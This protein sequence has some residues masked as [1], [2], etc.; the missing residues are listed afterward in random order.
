M[1]QESIVLQKLHNA[2]FE[3]ESDQQKYDLL[4]SISD[5]IDETRLDPTSTSDIELPS[6]VITKGRPKNTK[7][8]RIPSQFEI[9]EIK[10]RK[11]IK[12]KRAICES[13]RQSSSDDNDEIFIFPQ[14][15]KRK[16][17]EMEFLENLNNKKKYESL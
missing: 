17:R 9:K 2:I 6:D 11:K 14:N 15:G 5:L 8:A 1:E 3:M 7:N 16:D 4:S 10:N 13:D 12:N